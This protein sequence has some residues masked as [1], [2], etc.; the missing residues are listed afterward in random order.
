MKKYG[1]VCKLLVMLIILTLLGVVLDSCA[2]YRTGDSDDVKTMLLHMSEERIKSA[3]MIECLQEISGST[4][5][6][7]PYFLTYSYMLKGYNNDDGKK[8]VIDSTDKRFNTMVFDV[9]YVERIQLDER[10]RMAVYTGIIT[11]KERGQ[12]FDIL[13]TI[14]DGKDSVC[15]KL[16]KISKIGL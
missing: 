1:D 7:D 12:M 9:D 15:V 6:L 16:I 14:S 3:V 10:H 8:Q 13:Y 11:E 4:D 2:K 5:Y